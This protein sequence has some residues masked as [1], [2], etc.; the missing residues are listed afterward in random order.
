MISSLMMFYKDMICFSFIFN[1]WSL[2]GGAWTAGQSDFAQYVIIDLGEK[3]NISSITTQG[4]PYTNE[5]VQEYRIEY[6]ND[7]QDFANYRDRNGNIK[8]RRIHLKKRN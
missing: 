3:Y 5:Y 1:E 6:G 4:R 2:G 7:G 8:V